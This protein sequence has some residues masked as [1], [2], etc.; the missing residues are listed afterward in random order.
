MTIRRL[1]ASVSDSACVEERICLAVERNRRQL[2]RSAA[3]RD[4]DIFGGASICSIR[5]FDFNITARN[6][7]PLPD[8]V[9]DLVLAKQIPDAAGH[10]LHDVVLERHHDRQIDGGIL[11]LDAAV[12]E[13]MLEIV[14]PIRTVEQRLGGN[15][16]DVQARAAQKFPLDA[17]DLHSKLRGA[18]RGGVSAGSGADDDQIEISLCHVCGILGGPIP[19][20]HW[21]SLASEEPTPYFAASRIEEKGGQL[22][23]R[24]RCRASI[25]PKQ[26][27]NRILQVVKSGKLHPRPGMQGVRKRIGG[28]FRRETRGALIL[29]DRGGSSAAHRTGD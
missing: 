20:R 9:F 25:N 24:F 16:A 7:P 21:S 3:G 28:L 17:G 1:G 15:A 10:F 26:I 2:D 4:Q 27:D 12:G 6:D 23:S 22:W 11:R 8:Q 19:R 18:D 14:K 13:M 5:A 29:L